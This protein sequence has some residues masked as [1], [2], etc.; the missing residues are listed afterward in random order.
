MKIRV[1]KTT[2]IYLPSNFKVGELRAALAEFDD[3]ASIH[4][5][6]KQALPQDQ[7]DWDSAT[8]KVRPV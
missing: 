3:E 2:S 7:R 6:V 5:T 8:L 1:D 4:M